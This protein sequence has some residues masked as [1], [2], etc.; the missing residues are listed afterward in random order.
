MTSTGVWLAAAALL[1]AAGAAGSGSAFAAA[2]ADTQQRD[3]PSVFAIGD[4]VMLGAVGCMEARGWA[5]DALGNRQV[6]AAEMQL[7]AAADLPAQVVVHAGTNGGADRGD[8]AAVMRT[9]GRGHDVVWLT[10]QLPD[11]TSRYTFEESTN[12]AIRA[13]PDRFPN[14]YVAD[15]NQASDEHPEWTGGDGIH[16]TVAGCRGY[17]RLIARTL[18][19]AWETHHYVPMGRPLAV[20]NG[21][22]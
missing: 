17:T 4:S 7:R 8:L 2:P 12:E 20:G 19:D 21:A 10:I 16:L 9:I 11:G 3:R 1:A 18:R 15:W 22:G 5:V 14:A 13:L 6:T